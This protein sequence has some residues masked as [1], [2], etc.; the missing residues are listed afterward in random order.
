MDHSAAVR[1]VQRVSNLAAELENLVERKRAL[2]ETFRKSL[3]LEALHDEVVHPVLMADVVQHTN[4]RMIQAGNRF[5]FAFEALLPNGII[6]KLWRQNLYRHSA[7]KTRVAP[8][9]HLAHAARAERRHDLIWTKFAPCGE[10]HDW[11]K[12]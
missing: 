12:L 1:F 7:I 3:A 5:G 9:K 2:F 4:V 6:R 8:A 10:A 11:R